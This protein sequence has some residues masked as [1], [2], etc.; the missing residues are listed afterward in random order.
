[1]LLRQVDDVLAAAAPATIAA[2]ARADA[3]QLRSAALTVLSHVVATVLKDPEFR[4]VADAA[5]ARIFRLIDDEEGPG[6]RAELRSLAISLLSFRG[7]ALRPA[8]QAKAQALLRSL[9]RQAPPYEHLKGAWRFARASA[10]EFFPGEI[11]LLQA[12]HKFKK[13]ETPAD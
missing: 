2:E 11:E 4:A 12:D 3:D 9:R 7:P 6:G 5:A 1:H 8:D 10:Y 13:I